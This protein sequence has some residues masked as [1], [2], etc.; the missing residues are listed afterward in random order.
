MRYFSNT[1]VVLTCLALMLG[2]CDDNNDNI[3]WL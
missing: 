1:F 3:K 2:G